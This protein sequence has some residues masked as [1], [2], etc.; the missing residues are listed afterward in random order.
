MT[1]RG[2]FV[3]SLLLF[4]VASSSSAQTVD[5]ILAKVFAARGGLAKIRAV[6]TERVSGTITFGAE[7]SGPFMVE[8]QRPLKM[9]M[10]LT[11]QNQTLVRVYDGKSAGWA[12][13]PFGGKM[14]P[15]PMTEDELKNISD[16]SDFDGQFV[17]A[18]RKGNQVV[19]AGKDKV[20]DK[21]AWR[22]KLTTKSG[23][24]R[25]YLFDSSSFLLLKWEGKRKFEGKE[26]PV[27]SY[28]RDYRDVSGL[29]FAFL[30]ESG[31]SAAEIN[32][33]IAIDKIELN[34]QIDA[35]A[36]GKPATPA[37]PGSPPPVPGTPEAPATPPPASEAPKP[38]ALA[39]PAP[40]PQASATLNAPTS[41]ALEGRVSARPVPAELASAQ[42]SS[43]PRGSCSA[44]RMPRQF[45]T[46]YYHG[47]RNTNDRGPRWNT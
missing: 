9:H 32:Q 40:M 34:P 6:K 39:A 33:K 28:F 38:Q 17:D 26:F 47:E 23:E 45:S 29:K 4:F 1:R 7:T 22:I 36:F 14:N 37:V 15:E 18:K 46:G 44:A 5:Q 30:I 3:T 16:E 42:S 25:S 41:A 27:E 20:G 43:L 11:I 12:N 31:S 2:F 13:N 35:A 21:D 8:F 19:L 24:A 10:Q